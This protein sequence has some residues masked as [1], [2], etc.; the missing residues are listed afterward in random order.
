[1][2]FFCNNMTGEFIGIWKY[3]TWTR[4]INWIKITISYHWS[5]WSKHP[6]QWGVPMSI[7]VE[8]TT[9]CNL[10]CP[11][12]P[13]GL[14]SF[15]R[16]TG[17]MNFELFQKI[18]GQLGKELLYVNLYFQG[19]PYLNPQ[20]TEFVAHAH[21]L[22]L[23]TSTSTNGHF[24]SDEQAKK[25]IASGLDRLIIS[26]DGIDQLTYE[27]Y[28]KGGKYET[29]IEGIKRLVK[30][31]KEMKSI[32][33]YLVIQ[34][35]VVKPNEHQILAVQELGKQLGVNKVSFKSAQLN[36]FENGN[37]LMPNDLKYSRYKMTPNGKYELKNKLKNQ[38]WRL[39]SGSVI[40]W[41]G[42]VV[43]CCFD[44][45][46]AF[47]MGKIDEKVSFATIWGNEKYK[48][49]RQGVLTSRKTH[50]IC[51]NCSEGSKVWV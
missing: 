31:K 35:L 16:A 14:K 44:K 48:Y 50:S 6:V 21:A 47:K 4:I 38:C 39:W 23:F 46:A 15:S 5:N 17:R 34:F 26:L 7:S 49:F 8:P 12:C 41:D 36:D 10:G 1:M 30:W 11:E 9:A 43:P 33:P 40:T 2:M 19:E 45:D 51:S 29:V 24:I 42:M 27:Q 22:K 18:V 37:E 20:F 32:T 28:R 13:S 25:T 3:L